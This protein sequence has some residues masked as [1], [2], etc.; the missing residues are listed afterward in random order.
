[1]ISNPN[2]VSQIAK[3]PHLS[4]EQL[5]SYISDKSNPLSPFALATLQSK[6]IARKKF[7]T[8]EAPKQTV[9][10]QVEAE[11]DAPLGI[12]GLQGQQPAPA[13]QAGPAPIPIQQPQ[14]PQGMAGGG[15]VAFDEGGVASLPLRD[16]MYNEDS[17]AHGGIVGFDG[18]N[19]SYV[20][21]QGLTQ[22]SFDKL[23]PEQQQMYTDAY[24]NKQ[25]MGNASK[26]LLTPA[27][28]VGGIESNILRGVNNLITPIGKAVG[29]THPLTKDMPYYS[30]GEM[31]P[32]M[33]TYPRAP[34]EIRALLPTG[35]KPNARPQSTAV[36]PTAVPTGAVPETKAPAAT[37]A[38]TANP[39]TTGGVA[40]L[41]RPQDTGLSPYTVEEYT[42]EKI[43]ALP[44]FDR[45]K[46]NEERKQMLID[47]GVDP[48]FYTKQAAKNETEREALKGERT[49]AG[50]SAALRAGLGMM[51]GKSTNPWANI[52]EG[53][54]A[55]LA[56][57]G[58]D[59]KDIKSDEKLLRAADDK[60]AEAQYLQ[61]RG[62]A[63]GAM[64]AMKE[65]EALI[66]SVD[67]MNVQARNVNKT[68][69]TGDKNK[70]R[71]DVFKNEQEN[72][73][74]AIQQAGETERSRN[75]IAASERATK[76]TQ[77]LNLSFKQQESYNKAIDNTNAALTLQYGAG[78]GNQM[79]PEEYS[80]IYFTELQKQQNQLGLKPLVPNASI[81]G[82][83]EGAT[84]KGSRPVK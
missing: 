82:M 81:S 21:Y 66:A 22:E 11:A 41:L 7:G 27:N 61:G 83:P 20:E 49:D 60:L 50:W 12:A 80:K 43:N 46:Y 48:E 18:R 58:T 40:N 64:K 38:P 76:A 53:A 23:S 36:A 37:A 44:A 16:D 72:T 77:D 51:G 75:Q 45:A 62:D 42:P 54:T 1:M 63:E 10:D 30:F 47:A 52:S 55:G 68:A 14:A 78:F 19:G 24:R 3:L 31:V 74:L 9:A 84:F 4:D 29:V 70:M 69:F 28:I 5:K 67:A 6:A 73:R 26:A 65:R 35:T 57:Y 33:G 79:P 56:Q 71:S 32:D 13:P 15:M 8:P 34:K 17:F 25:I 39:A 2:L 59:I